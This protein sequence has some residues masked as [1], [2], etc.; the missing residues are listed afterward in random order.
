MRSLRSDAAALLTLSPDVADVTIHWHYL[1][2]VHHKRS[3]GK[4]HL[5]LTDHDDR[6]VHVA[7]PY[8]EHD[9]LLAPYLAQ[10]RLELQ[11]PWTHGPAYLP[12]E[13]A[14]NGGWVFSTAGAEHDR[15]A[16][17]GS[18]A[19]EEGPTKPPGWQTFH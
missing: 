5:D 17:T 6:R 4:H 3:D 16:L 2:V 13:R 7:L 9:S 1:P 12:V 10:Y 18:E 19:E 8:P 15:Q 14:K 11:D